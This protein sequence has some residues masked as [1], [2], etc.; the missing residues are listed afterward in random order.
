MSEKLTAAGTPDQR[1]REARA[2]RDGDRAPRR[3]RQRGVFNGTNKKLDVITQIPGYHLHILNDSPGRIDRAVAGGY[4]FVMQGEV[5]L[6]ESNK[7]VDS[8]SAVDGKIRF[9]VGTTDQNEPLYAYLMKIPQEWYDEDQAEI[10]AQIA[11]K[12]APIRNG[13]GLQADMVGE[14]YVPDGRKQAV[15]MKR[16][17][18]DMKQ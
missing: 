11:A 5:A 10:A 9:I 8:N 6:G 17:P 13:K 14:S 15:I 1:T 2:T 7:V 12:E 16:G 18:L 3:E 4:E